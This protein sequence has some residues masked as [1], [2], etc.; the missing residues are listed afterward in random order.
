[1]QFTIVVIVVVMSSNDGSHGFN[2]IW[3]PPS[4]YTMCVCVEIK[5]AGMMIFC[6]NARTA[7]LEP[8]HL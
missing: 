6:L 8:T 4:K 3:Q 2:D 7:F 1:M 5:K